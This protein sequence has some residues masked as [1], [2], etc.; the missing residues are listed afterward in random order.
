MTL[1]LVSAAKVSAMNRWGSEDA[2]E[3]EMRTRTAKAEAAYEARKKAFTSQSPGPAMESARPLV[4]RSE[5]TGHQDKPRRFPSRPRILNLEHETNF[6]GENQQKNHTVC[7]EKYGFF[8]VVNDFYFDGG[9]TVVVEEDDREYFFPH[10]YDIWE[11]SK[12]CE[13]FECTCPSETEIE[14]AMERSHGQKLVEAL[15][16][17]RHGTTIQIAASCGSPSTGL[18]VDTS[19]RLVGTEDH[20]IRTWN[21]PLVVRAPSIVRHLEVRHE[22][23]PM[24]E[25]EWCDY[26]AHDGSD[27]SA[28]LLDDA[29]VEN[30]SL[31]QYDSLGVC[32]LV[33][34]GRVVAN[35]NLF[36]GGLC[37]V[38]VA[39]IT[40][41]AAT[42]VH[43]ERNTFRF[44][45]RGLN[46]G[47]ARCHVGQDNAAILAAN[48]FRE[49]K[50]EDRIHDHQDGVKLTVWCCSFKIL[51][52]TTDAPFHVPEDSGD[53]YFSL[54]EVIAACNTEN[55]K[56]LALKAPGAQD[57][58]DTIAEGTG[59]VVETTAADSE[60]IVGA[61]LQGLAG[62]QYSRVEVDWVC[63]D[64][65]WTLTVDPSSGYDDVVGRRCKPGLHCHGAKSA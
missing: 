17:A 27:T 26:P 15:K 19:V 51:A 65:S 13:E 58:M 43:P 45:C 9:P 61:I 57:E 59:G 23:P 40:D 21:A 24:T 2:F 46:K 25:D 64:G 54:D 14:R 48:T 8:T 16:T 33:Q 53:E 22:L 18:I 42:T 49:I 62:V 38:D 30:C 36:L 34:M 11:C 39:P 10:V 44:N 6:V 47:P 1:T 37:G 63:E 41:V 4:S 60:D 55:I 56:I 32:L 5:S 35:R 12:S 28:V 20:H 3:Q 29:L 7:G 52:I 50:Q 31:G